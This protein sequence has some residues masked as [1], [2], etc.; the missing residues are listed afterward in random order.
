[1]AKV[2][3]NISGHLLL[4]EMQP[5]A[6]VMFVLVPKL[7]LPD[8]TQGLYHRLLAMITSVIL[9]VDILV[10]TNSTLRTHYGMALVAGVLAP[11]VSSTIHHG[12]VSNYLNPPLTILS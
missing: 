2:L 4:Q 3:E 7:T 11:A 1:M 12:S 8:S 5:I 10:Q 9:A 6:L